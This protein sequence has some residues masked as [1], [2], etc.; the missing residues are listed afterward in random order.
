[1]SEICHRFLGPHLDK[2]LTD[3]ISRR[4][5][6]V[7]AMGVPF[8]PPRDLQPGNAECILA[9]KNSLMAFDA[10]QFANLSSTFTSHCVLL[11]CCAVVLVAENIYSRFSAPEALRRTMVEHMR[12]IWFSEIKLA[13]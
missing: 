11:L 5:L 1:M 7:F 9:D 2:N 13:V 10:L 12:R 8:V 3:E 4:I 6:N